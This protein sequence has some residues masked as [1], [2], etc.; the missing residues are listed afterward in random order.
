MTPNAVR[1]LD[2]IRR[3]LGDRPTFVLRPTLV[4]MVLRL[5]WHATSDTITELAKLGH[6]VAI[7][8]N[9]RTNIIWRLADVPVPLPPDAQIPRERFVG[10]FSTRAEKC[11]CVL[12]FLMSQHRVGVPFQCGQ[13]ELKI[14]LCTS[15]PTVANALR[16][17]AAS[18]VLKV[19]AAEKA[20]GGIKPGGKTATTFVLTGRPLADEIKIARRTTLRPRETYDVS[21]KSNKAAGLTARADAE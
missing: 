2:V 19:V 1:L 18:G 13:N 7:A 5:N 16:D 12:A 3:D 6:L 4:A 21:H 11:E 17:L 10:R 15:G 9:P 8:R 20:R 14:S